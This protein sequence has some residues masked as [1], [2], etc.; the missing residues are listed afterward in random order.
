M[1]LPASAAVCI[2]SRGLQPNGLDKHC[3]CVLLPHTSQ[4]Q[5]PGPA[6]SEAAPAGQPNQASSPDRVSCLHAQGTQLPTAACSSSASV[7][8]NRFG[9]PVLS[10][11]LLP[12]VTPPLLPP[13]LLCPCAFCRPPVA[14]CHAEQ[15]E[16]AAAATVETA[17]NKKMDPS[18]FQPGATISYNPLLKKVKD[19]KVM[20]TRTRV[21]V[22]PPSSQSGNNGVIL[23][24]AGYVSSYTCSTC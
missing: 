17:A 15:Q 2:S 9:T 16:A 20:D 10:S 23:D 19:E 18:A 6:V 11:T 13:P 4:N 22:V 5:Q 3:C 1:L 7:R 21:G 8:S 24:D 12:Q 14:V